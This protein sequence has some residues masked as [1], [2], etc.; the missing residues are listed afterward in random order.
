M[1]ERA[2]GLST[3]LV[4]TSG[5]DDFYATNAET[6]CKV[7]KENKIPYI[8]MLSPGKHSWKYWGFALEVHLQIFKAIL[9]GKNLGF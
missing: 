6:F 8:L 9:E 3:P 5:Y 4:V 1:A 7:C 2:K